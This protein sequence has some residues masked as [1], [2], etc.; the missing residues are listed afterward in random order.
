MTNNMKQKNYNIWTLLKSHKKL[1]K[2]LIWEFLRVDNTEM[3][4]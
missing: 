3:N 2:W 4:Q 1:M